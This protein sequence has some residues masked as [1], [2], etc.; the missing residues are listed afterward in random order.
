[1]SA[2]LH[3]F[4]RNLRI[5]G[6][7]FFSFFCLLIF[8]FRGWIFEKNRFLKLKMADK[9]HIENRFGY[10]SAYTLLNAKFGPERK[11]HMQI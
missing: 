5:A 11:N 3:V 9:R 1:V 2:Q 6:S 8:L 10:I 4:A 7:S